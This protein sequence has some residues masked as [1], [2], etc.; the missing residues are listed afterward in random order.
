MASCA[1]FVGGRVPRRPEGY[2]IDRPESVEDSQQR[3]AV[4]EGDIRPDLHKG[5]SSRRAAITAASVLS[6]YGQRLP[7]AQA[8]EPKVTMRCA[9]DIQ[10]GFDRSAPMRRLVIGLFGEEAPVLTRNFYQAFTGSYPK[11]N[12][13]YVDY[14]FADVKAVF[15]DRAVVWA[16]FPNGNIIRRRTFKR[17]GPNY[18]DTILEIPLAQEDT[19]TNETNSLRHDIPG[20][21]SMPRG[22]QTFNFAVA[23]VA[24][25]PWLDETN[26]VIGQVLEGFDIIEEINQIKVKGKAFGEELIGA[27]GG[28]GD[29]RFEIAQNNKFKPLKRVRIYGVE[30]LE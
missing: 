4:V 1:A 27:L 20:R 18:I 10:I 12:G 13:G 17:Q 2:Q 28:A 3:V 11:D 19:A 15:K 22:G 6:I 9:F 16:D 24:P 5:G 30:V 26:V 25:A 7:S 21:V 29:I 14:R 23:P 8:S